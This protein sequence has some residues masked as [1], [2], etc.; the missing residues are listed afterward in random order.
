MRNWQDHE[1]GQ[2]NELHMNSVNCFHG[3]AALRRVPDFTKKKDNLEQMSL[4]WQ[5]WEDRRETQDKA[6]EKKCF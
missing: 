6:K 2:K 1:D 5:S 3:E 4:K